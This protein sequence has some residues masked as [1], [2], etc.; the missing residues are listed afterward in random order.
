MA[1]PG[2]AVR[3]AAM[4]Y[5]LALGAFF[6]SSYAFS[7]WIASHRSHVPSIVFSWERHIPFLAWTI[8]PYWSIDL[9]YCWSFFVC[10]TRAE[11]NQHVRRLLAAQ[12]LCVT[13][14]LLFPLRFSF[15]RPET[16]GIFSQ[17]FHAL[18][19]FDGPFNQAPSLHLSLAVILAAGYLQYLKGPARW[20][21]T[22][23][24]TLIGISAVTTYQHHFLDIPTGVWVGLLCCAAFPAG[25]PLDPVIRHSRSWKLSGLY[26]VGFLLLTAFA[27]GIGG[28][29]LWLLWPAGAC[30]IVAGIYFFGDPRLFRKQRGSRPP[31]MQWLLAPCLAAAW[32]NSR[33]WTCRD[34]HAVEIAAGVWLGRVPGLHDRPGIVSIVDLTAEL[35][36]RTKGIEYRN[37]P[38]LDLATPSRE[39]LDSAVAAIEDLAGHRPTLVCCALGYSRSAAAVAA[40][41]VATGGASDMEAAIQM[42]RLRRNRIVLSVQNSVLNSWAA[43]RRTT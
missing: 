39:Q 23:W 15:A 11:L 25:Q 16:Y 28:W 34:P 7:N 19:K 29:A 42:I 6:C 21:L 27:V 37:V 17:M 32:M 13:C 36:V 24:L 38:M 20:L 40:W 26:L 41:L 9:L 43:A 4:S 12:I 14:F 8:V 3:Y 2:Q 18:A 1:K 5:M 10:R 31:V 35:S 33:L 22:A 30:L